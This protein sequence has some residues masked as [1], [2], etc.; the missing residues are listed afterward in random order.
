MAGAVARREAAALAQRPGDALAWGQ[1]RLAEAGPP[2]VGRVA[3]HDGRALPAGALLARR[4]AALVEP[5]RDRPDAQALYGVPGVGLAHHRRFGL[6]NLVARRPGIALA[7]VEVAIGRAAQHVDLPLA[8]AMQLAAPGPLEDL[9]PFVLG[10]HALELEQQP[11]LRRL[12]A[13]GLD[14]QNLDAG[15]GELLDQ[16]HLMDV[17]PAQAI[18]RMDQ[19]RLDRPLG[20]QIAD[21]FQPGADQLGA[22]EAV[23]LDDP[24][25]RHAVV[26]APGKLDQRRRL[27]RDRLLLPLPDTRA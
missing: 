22:A 7:D 9:G 24:L 21:P 17:F 2:L 6:E 10:E 18:R 16:Q 14:E 23:I 5:G 13:G 25:G 11:V 20:R 15:A 19:D 27:A 3:Q 1:L 26:V 8:G 12:R 4:H